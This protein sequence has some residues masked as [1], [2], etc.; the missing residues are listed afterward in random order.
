MFKLTKKTKEKKSKAVQ[1]SNK[2]TAFDSVSIRRR[3]DHY[4]RFAR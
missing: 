4:S 2:S 3:A 1:L